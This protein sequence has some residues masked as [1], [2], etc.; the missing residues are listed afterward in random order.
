[1]PPHPASCPYTGACLEVTGDLSLITIPLILTQCST[2]EAGHELPRG[3]GECWTQ[4]KNSEAGVGAGCRCAGQALEED[5]RGPLSGGAQQ[6]VH[7]VPVSSSATVSL[8]GCCLFL[9]SC[10]DVQGVTS[11]P[12]IAP[13]LS[14]KGLSG[15]TSVTPWQRAVTVVFWV[16]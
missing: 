12:L 15:A 16:Q 14:G 13:S 8:W 11:G 9:A 7:V 2:G 3:S 6:A 4:R 10:P 5:P 1:M